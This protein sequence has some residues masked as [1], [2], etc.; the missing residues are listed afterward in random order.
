MEKAPQHCANT[1]RKIQGWFC[2]LL[3]DEAPGDC[4]EDGGVELG[5]A[6]CRN[7][8]KLSPI[9]SAPLCAFSQIER[10]GRRRA[11]DLI[12]QIPVSLRERIEDRF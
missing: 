9:L 5:S 12:V 7:P 1:R 6:A 8:V 11:L 10:D 3:R 4:E 2:R